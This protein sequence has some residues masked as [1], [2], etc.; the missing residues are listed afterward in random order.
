MNAVNEFN[1]SNGVI[2]QSWVTD[3]GK[4]KANIIMWYWQRGPHGCLG[5]IN[6]K[7]FHVQGHHH[8]GTDFLT[9]IN[10]RSPVVKAVKL[11]ACT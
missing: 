3:N 8:T 6:S 7:V 11:M 10:T 1:G 5:G 2:I 9:H 4:D